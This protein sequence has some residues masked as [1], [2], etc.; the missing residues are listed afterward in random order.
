MVIDKTFW[1]DRNVFLTGHT[2]FKGGWLSLWLRQLGAKVT[3]YALEPSTSPSLYKISHVANGMTSCFGDIRDL[4][5]LKKTM[6][7]VAPEV[8]IHMAAQP[9]VRASYQDPVNT[10]TTNVLGTVNLFEAVRFTPTVKV[11]LNITSDKC[12]ENLEW[13]WGYRENDRM[14]GHDPYSCSKGCAELVTASYYKSFLQEKQIGLASARAGNVIGG[15]DW[16]A[17]RIVPDAVR[18]FAAGKAV[19]LRNPKAIRP[20]QY[21]L[22][23]LAGYLMLCQRLYQQPQQFSQGWNFGP[24]QEDACSVSRLV[25][26]IAAQWEQGTGWEQDKRTNPHE[27]GYLKLDCSK[28]NAELQWRP[29][30]RLDRVVAETANWYKQALHETA[31]MRIY[32][33]R[34]IEVFQSELTV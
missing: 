2:G 23:P 32:S 22:E 18:A 16:S 8:V 7:E 4:D 13:P 6:Q 17:D 12:Y 14:G 24:Q 20:W 29:L 27:A 5:L 1:R 25:E 30:W 9:L 10:Y 26:M 31:D 21:V 3:G 33:E 11:V 15:G 19:T 34:Q 28:A